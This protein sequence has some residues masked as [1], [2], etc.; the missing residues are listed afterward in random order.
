MDGRSQ[1]K[2]KV[3]LVP[4][5]P[6]IGSVV[7]VATLNAA[8]EKRISEAQR[9]TRERNTALDALEDWYIEFRELSR[10]VLM[11]DPQY[12]E[13]LGLGIVA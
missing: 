7:A 1:M 12:L 10:I 11:D 9:A 2:Y 13:A 3:V 4:Y 6:G 5:P 8:Q